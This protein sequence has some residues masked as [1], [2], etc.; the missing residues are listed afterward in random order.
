VVVSTDAP[1]PDENNRVTSKLAAVLGPGESADAA[2]PKCE[3]HGE[4]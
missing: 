2:N 4:K 3:V 1:F